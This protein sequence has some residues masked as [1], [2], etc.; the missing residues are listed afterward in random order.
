MKQHYRPMLAKQAEA[1]FNSKD[2]IF[3]IKWDG[4]RAI[5]YVNADLSMKTRNNKELAYNFPELEELKDLTKNAVIDGEIVVMRE[6]TTDFQTLIERSRSTSVRDIEFKAKKFPATYIVFDIL[7][8]DEKPLIDLPL[9]ERKSLMKEYVKEG[10]HVVLSLF[11][12]EEG[13]TYYEAA[14]QKGVEGIIAKKKD[15]RYEPGVRSNN[16]LKIKPILSCDCVIFGYT[17]GQG[18]RGETFGA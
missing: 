8:K 14:L 18:K 1:P 12:E 4:I 17:A 3:E 11:A 9:I 15:S 10:K 7:E 2:W 13:I 16:W 5:S 6:R